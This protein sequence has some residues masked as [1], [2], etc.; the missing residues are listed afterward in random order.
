MTRTMSFSIKH[1]IGTSLEFCS[2]IK[3]DRCVN[4]KYTIR[5]IFLKFIQQYCYTLKYINCEMSEL[6]IVWPC[7]TSN[8]EMSGPENQPTEN[9]PTLQISLTEKCPDWEM[10]V[11]LHS[12]IS[13]SLTQTISDLMLVVGRCRDIAAFDIYGIWKSN[14]FKKTVYTKIQ[15]IEWEIK[16]ELFYPK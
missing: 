15:W 3:S 5:I 12:L 10:S 4:I 13:I 9:C 11:F 7:K 6:R 14:C 16:S 8:C 2:S 1:L